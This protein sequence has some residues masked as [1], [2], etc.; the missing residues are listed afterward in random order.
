M[1]SRHRAVAATNRAQDGAAVPER[2]PQLGE[3]AV[4]QLTERDRVDVVPLEGLR[5]ATETATLEPF[6]QLRHG[7]SSVATLRP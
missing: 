5:I 3:V 2:H 1:S 7:P 6:T 4:G